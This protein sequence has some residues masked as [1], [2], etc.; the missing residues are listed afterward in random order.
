MPLPFRGGEADAARVTGASALALS[1]GEVCAV[2][3]ECGEDGVIG[4]G[5]HG[6]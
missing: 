3:F 4:C 2:L 5:M 6:R 1:A